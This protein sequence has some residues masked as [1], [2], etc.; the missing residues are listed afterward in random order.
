MIPLVTSSGSFFQLSTGLALALPLLAGSAAGL[1]GASEPPLAAPAGSAERTQVAVAVGRVQPFDT[2]WSIA[3]VSLTDPKIAD[4]DVLTS[5]L[6]VLTG[7]SAGVTDV[8]IWNDE[9]ESHTLSVEV[10]EDLERLRADLATMFPSAALEVSHS[11]GVTVL[12]GTLALQEDADELHAYLEACGI[13]Y[14]D[15]TEVAGI[16]Q[17]QVEVRIAEVS[18][19]ALRTLGINAFA[20]NDEAFIGSMVGADGV[21][22]INPISIGPRKG[23][24]AINEVPF[25]YNGDTQVTPAVTMF[26]GLHAN[27]EVFVQALQEN[28]YLRILAE[29]NLVALSG[30]EASFLAGGEFPIPVVQ[31]SLG[32]A[33]AGTAITVEFKPFGVGLSFRPEVLGD[34]GIRLRVSSEVSDLSSSGAV[35]V[36]GF[37][38]PAVSTR[39]AETTLEL[40]SG[41]TFAM[42]G[43]LNEATS[44]ISS[45]V[46]G[47][48]SIPILGPLFRSVRYQRGE[49]ELVLLVTASLVEP[50][51]EQILP[52]LPGTTH[53]DPSDW[54]LY[55]EGRIEGGPPPR[56]GPKEERWLREKGLGDLRGPGAWATHGGAPAPS[57]APATEEPGPAQPPPTPGESS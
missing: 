11:Q 24:R 15:G 14:V 20:T 53:V 26:A 2:P 9:G 1:D 27:L 28:Q 57:E 37:S 49:T 5:R 33:A 8:L 47:L 6:L 41:E 10:H 38:I 32:G 45:E 22:P 7:R 23:H 13:R 35:V 43:L 25:V 48:G 54:E 21:G 42:A 29:P 55:M 52:P 46:P 31:G 40:Q 12:G 34:G 17:V 4:V 3:G 16:R 30:E 19:S 50:M 44:A 36:E 18:R 56:I 51:S 39:R